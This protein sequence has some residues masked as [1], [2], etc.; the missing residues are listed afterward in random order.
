MLSRDV[1]QT[2]LNF[3]HRV[4]Y[5][6]EASTVRRQFYAVSGRPPNTLKFLTPSGLPTRS[7][8]RPLPQGRDL[9]RIEEEEDSA[10]LWTVQPKVRTV[11]AMQRM[12]CS[13]AQAT[14]RPAQCRGLSAPMQRALPVLLTMN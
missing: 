14:D 7:A 12:R 11:G 8:I 1:L 4:A 9:G 13:Y 5:Q 3:L 2:R 6:S 10:P